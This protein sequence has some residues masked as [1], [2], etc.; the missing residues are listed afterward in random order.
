MTFLF[1][2]HTHLDSHP[3]LPHRFSKH[4][5]YPPDLKHNIQSLEDDNAKLPGRS[6][7]KLSTGRGI[8]RFLSHRLQ[9]WP[10]HDCGHR[11]EEIVNPRFKVNL[12]TCRDIIK[13]FPHEYTIA[14]N[15]DFNTS[16][17]LEKIR[18]YYSNYALLQL[19][20]RK[21][22]MQRAVP[23]N[24]HRRHQRFPFETKSLLICRSS[25][26]AW[27]SFDCGSRLEINPGVFVS[28]DTPDILGAYRLSGTLQSS[29]VKGSSIQLLLCEHL[30]FH[31]I[32]AI[33]L[34]AGVASR[35]SGYHAA[36]E[37]AQ[38]GSEDT[39]TTHPDSAQQLSSPGT[40]VTSISKFKTCGTRTYVRPIRRLST[41]RRMCAK[42]FFPTNTTVVLGARTKV[43]LL[44]TPDAREAC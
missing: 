28:S 40:D 11:L 43:L 36:Y 24:D 17:N 29:R 39:D 23:E 19:L 25:P 12:F 35:R 37:E 1:P 7:T 8:C 14:C 34:P 3:S 21:A 16:T 2:L 9:R 41:S 13:I 6:V 31:H 4:D 38:S 30:D 32:Q 33:S 27:R 10:W 42:P 44:L 22:L 15:F 18:L 20:L 5:P 26:P